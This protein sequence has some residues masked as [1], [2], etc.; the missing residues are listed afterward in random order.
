MEPND[1]PNVCIP[2]VLP[3]EAAAE[4]LKFLRNLTET[5]ERSLHGSE[6]GPHLVRYP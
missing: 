5:L 4:L 2:L 6:Q 3:D 1:L